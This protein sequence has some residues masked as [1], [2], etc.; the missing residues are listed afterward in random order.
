[1]EVAEYIKLFTISVVILAAAW[2]LSAK[3][4][5]LSTVMEDIKDNHLPHIYEEL[6]DLSTEIR[7]HHGSN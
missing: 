1:M 5:Y 2:R 7:R 4:T 3:L 6:K